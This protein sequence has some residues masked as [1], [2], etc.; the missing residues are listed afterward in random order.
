[1][2][3]NAIEATRRIREAD[4]I[5]VGVGGAV[6]LI[7]VIVVSTGSVSAISP[8]YTI[9][10][11]KLFNQSKEVVNESIVSGNN[12]S[13]ARKDA[14]QYVD[15]ELSA[16]EISIYN[17]HTD[18]V[19]EL[20]S[21][22]KSY[23]EPMDNFTI[24]SVYNPDYFTPHLG[25]GI[26]VYN[27]THY[28]LNGSTVEFDTLSDQSDFED[29]GLLAPNRSTYG[30]ACEVTE[31]DGDGT[32]MNTTVWGIAVNDVSQA[33][34]SLYSRIDGYTPSGIII[35]GPIPSY[36]GAAYSNAYC[37]NS[38]VGPG[39]GAYSMSGESIDMTIKRDGSIV[40]SATIPQ[41]GDII[42]RYATIS[43]DND[44]LLGS[45]DCRLIG[46]TAHLST[47]NDTATKDILYA[48]G[49]GFGETENQYGNLT[50]KDMDS[51]DL[52]TDRF[53]KF[54]V[55]ALNVSEVSAE[56]KFNLW[57]IGDADTPVSV[58]I[59]AQGY[60]PRTYNVSNLNKSHTVRLKS[61]NN[62]RENRTDKRNYSDIIDVEPLPGIIGPA[63][64]SP[65]GEFDYT[66]V[67]GGG[68]L[69]Q[70]SGTGI[71]LIVVALGGYVI[72]REVDVK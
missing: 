20:V 43:V 70:G 60:Y 56:S 68:D 63:N 19:S 58:N 42:D 71:L 64:D 37:R 54:N 15:S 62:L 36:R 53:V 10:E 38:P 30:H 67:I 16:T 33:Q 69:P 57:K 44:A 40:G 51:G 47:S 18:A 59:S 27:Q 34:S 3:R 21:S 25:K 23:D 72:Y 45:R 46:F 26:I 1:M 24:S 4:P 32:T 55:S 12:L 11:D 66:P 7:L 35:R 29:C 65:T 61:G 52:L 6:L 13:E 17:Q 49:D 8:D 50:V 2:D 22:I 31:L 41:N 39:I 5:V 14:K 48:V 28:T 9:K